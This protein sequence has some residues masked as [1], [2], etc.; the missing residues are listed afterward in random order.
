MN[1]PDEIAALADEASRLS[2]IVQGR[3]ILD[4]LRRLE[5]ALRLSA[6]SSGDGVRERDA[7]NDVGMF[8]RILRRSSGT[9]LD[10]YTLD[11][12]R[13]DYDKAR[14]SY[15]LLKA[16]LA[17]AEKAGDASISPPPRW[18]ENDGS[19][20]HPQTLAEW[21]WRADAAPHGFDRSLRRLN[22]ASDYEDS[23]APDQM[24]LVLRID[25]LRLIGGWTHKNAYFQMM[26]ERR[27]SATPTP[28]SADVAW[29]IQRLRSWEKDPAA[30]HRVNGRTR[31]LLKEAATMLAIQSAAHG[32]GT[33]GGEEKKA[34]SL[35]RSTSSPGKG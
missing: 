31:R 22:V 11:V 20:R 23:R 8:F 15:D 13:A 29:L 35:D 16:A 7:L 26:K 18:K 9:V 2:K 17:P 5:P 12:T 25:L 21:D 27:E 34:V 19:D 4:F 14:A 32:G 24:A 3:L 10:A 28:P 6:T 33:E 1:R 30:T